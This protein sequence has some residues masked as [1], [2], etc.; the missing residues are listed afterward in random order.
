MT[1]PNQQQEL[2]PG[3]NGRNL[4]AVWLPLVALILFACLASPALAATGLTIVNNTPPYTFTATNL[5]SADPAKTIDVSIWLNPHNRAEFDTLAGQLYDKTS[6]NYRKFL[7]RSEFASRFAPTAAEAKTVQRFFASHNLKVVK[8]APNNFFVR[9]RGT[10]GDVEAAFRV[11]LKNYQVGDQVVRA[12]D[13]DPFVDGAAAPLVKSVAGLDTSGFTHPLVVR[14]AAP[15]SL[16][17]L[18]ATSKFAASTAVATPSNFFTNNCFP[19]VEKETFSTANNGSFPIGTYTGSK[20]GIATPS[21]PGCGYTPAEI[22]AAYGLTSLYTAGY[23]GAGQTIGI[24]DWCGS[25]TILQDANGFSKFFGLP[26]LKMG[27]NF[28]ITYIPTPSLC[29]ASGN[30]EINLDVEW[31]HAIAPGANINLIV[32]PTN[33][34]QDIDE[35]EYISIVSGLA[36]VLSGSYGAP[37]NQV[38]Q[39]ELDNGNLISETAATLGIST[40]F[41]SGDNG[42]FS[43]TGTG[44][45]VSYPADL[46][47]AT[48]VGGSSLALN[49][50]NS[51]KWQYGWGNNEILLAE[52]GTIPDPPFNLGFVFGGG[53]GPTNCAV[54]TATTC[55][56]GFPKPAYQHKLPGTVRQVPDISWLADPFTPPLIYIT[57]PGL[58]PQIWEG[59][60]GTSAACP[61]FS[62][63]WAIANQEA[64]ALLGQAAPYVYSMPAST[65]TDIVPLNP[66]TNVKASIQEP[67]FTTNYSA[68]KTASVTGPFVSAIWDYANLQN[69]AFVITFGTDTSLKVK[70]GWD[71]VTGVGVPNGAA[72]TNYFL[73]AATQ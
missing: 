19:G 1:T 33:S 17:G 65:I 9:A 5:G 26:A 62:A 43:V 27:D 49:A 32:P 10:V 8:V 45:T 34:F 56:S 67:H 28:N 60:G 25:N 53:G 50:D 46:P 31:A 29:V 41:S 64:G 69:T 70:V 23:D 13:R 40:N 36:T 38:A 22:Q 72:F 15:S 68:A 24:I 37:E 16:N 55:V 39:S 52:D 42:D 71:N 59:I 51:I 18:G 35:A 20:L 7:N 58:Y 30:A 12:N 2:N 66:A 61:M 63:L 21:S 54:Q 73:P 57:I 48:G 4:W 44:I 11:Q 47:F 3:A 14:P 6:P